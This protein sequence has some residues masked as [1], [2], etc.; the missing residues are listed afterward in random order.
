[1]KNFFLGSRSAVMDGHE[2]LRIPSMCYLLCIVP[3][4]RGIL[5]DAVVGLYLNLSNNKE[6]ARFAMGA[7]KSMKL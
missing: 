6:S 4:E 3:T 1:M 5:P 2:S 7:L